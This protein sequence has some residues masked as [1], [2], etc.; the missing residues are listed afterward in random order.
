VSRSG[1]VL[2]GIAYG[3]GTFIATGN[4]GPMLISTDG[5]S[6]DTASPGPPEWLNEVAFANGLFVAHSYDAL[7]SSTDGLH[8][9]SH[10][11][12][13]STQPVSL[14]VGQFS[15]FLVGP[16]GAILESDPVVR[17]TLAL[18]DFP[19]LNIYGPTGH[20]FR[21]DSVDALTAAPAWQTQATLLFTNTAQ[22]WSDQ[23]PL[24]TARFY[25]TLLLP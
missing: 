22:V 12:P 18:A 9:D 2:N 20:L 11:V 25:R 3:S 14:S 17:L 24:S 15:F 10:P 23:R 16:Q 8:W 6:W 7:Y 13:V 19:Q 4:S 21:I 1:S 5:I